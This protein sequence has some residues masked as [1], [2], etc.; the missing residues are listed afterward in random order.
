MVGDLAVQIRGSV[1][2][3]LCGPGEL[4]LDQIMHKAD[5]N[6]YEVK[7]ARKALQTDQAAQMV[8]PIP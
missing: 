5:L 6:M 8:N 4:T 3:A 1:G 7:R 2:V